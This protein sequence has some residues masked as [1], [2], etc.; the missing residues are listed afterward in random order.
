MQSRR[1][2]RYWVDVPLQ[3]NDSFAAPSFVL[4]TRPLEHAATVHKFDITRQMFSSFTLTRAD[5]HPNQEWYDRRY[6]PHAKSRPINHQ[7]ESSHLKEVTRVTGLLHAM[8][9]TCENFLGLDRSQRI[10]SIAAR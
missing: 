1:E 3:C 10:S 4:E 5:K 7:Y 6:C 8:N 9:V 2:V